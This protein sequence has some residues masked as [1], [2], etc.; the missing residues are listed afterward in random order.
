MSAKYW[1]F[2][3]ILRWI[4]QVI[5]CYWCA[6]YFLDVCIHNI[7]DKEPILGTAVY[8][9]VLSQFSSYWFVFLF[10]LLSI[11]ITS[12]P[13]PSRVPEKESALFGQ[14][15]PLPTPHMPQTGLNNQCGFTGVD[16][17][18]LQQGSLILLVLESASGGGPWPGE[19]W[20]LNW[21]YSLLVMVNC[22]KER[23]V[24][25]CLFRKF[26]D[27]LQ[28]RTLLNLKHAPCQFNE[29]LFKI[30]IVSRRELHE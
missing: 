14:Q 20:E 6:S 17:L 21:I 3:F 11:N 13:L 10:Q 26:L 5:R 30:N 24:I 29:R 15:Q 18:Q 12:R 25:V 1:S 4:D 2:V 7:G 27:F 28:V 23:P 16:P 22:S 8:H 9:I 19:N